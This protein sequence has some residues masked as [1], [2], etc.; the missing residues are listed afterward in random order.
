MEDHWTTENV[1]FG[2]NNF[3]IQRCRMSRYLSIPSAEI[4]TS[5]G[6]VIGILHLRI[7]MFTRLQILIGQLVHSN[8]A[9]G[10]VYN[11]MVH[12]KGRC[13]NNQLLLGRCC[14]RQN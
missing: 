10:Y 12:S 13:Y 6:G 14:R 4:P 2:G 11:P 5:R 9:Y 1:E 7:F 3:F 8:D